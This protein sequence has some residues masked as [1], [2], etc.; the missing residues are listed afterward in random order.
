M[1][2][3]RL[4]IGSTTSWKTSNRSSAAFLFV[5]SCLFPGGVGQG[6]PPFLGFISARKTGAEGLS[7]R[8]A[9]SWPAGHG[10][11]RDGPGGGPRSIVEGSRLSSFCAADGS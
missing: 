6:T 10:P 9:L 8:Y 4:K 11:V 5:S 1:T 2:G 7:R 3:I